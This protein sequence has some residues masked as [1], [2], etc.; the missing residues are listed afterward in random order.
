M[1]SV[2]SDVSNIVD[3]QHGSF[4]LE[5]LIGHFGSSS[6]EYLSRHQIRSL[7]ASRVEL[8]KQA[9]LALAQLAPLHE[10]R[11]FHDAFGTRAGISLFLTRMFLLREFVSASVGLMASGRD[12]PF[13]ITSAKQEDLPKSAWSFLARSC[14]IYQALGRF[15]GE[16]PAI[17][18]G[19]ETKLPEPLPYVVWLKE[20]RLDSRVAA[21]PA[22]VLRGKDGAVIPDVQFAP[23]GFDVLLEGSAQ[24]LQRNLIENLWGREVAETAFTLTNIS[25]HQRDADPISP[26]ERD[27]QSSALTAPAS[28]PKYNLTDLMISRY[29]G[30]TFSRKSVIALTDRALSE[31]FIGVNEAGEIRM[32]CPGVEFADSLPEIGSE[33]IVAG[34]IPPP[35]SAQYYVELRKSIR[36]TAPLEALGNDLPQALHDIETMSR[37]VAHEIILPMLDARLATSGKL[38][39][40]PKCYFDNL[41]T[42]PRIPF[43]LQPDGRVTTHAPLAIQ[44]AWARTVMMDRIMMQ[45]IGGDPIIRCPRAHALAPGMERINYALEGDCQNYV[46]ADL[47]GRHKSGASLG[48]LPNCQFAHTLH[49]LGFATSGAGQEAVSR[50]FGLAK[51]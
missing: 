1:T 9:D 51:L 3:R 39:S 42:L 49:E 28:V 30:Q 37:W 31:S 45:L 12:W 13:P 34:D 25:G 36:M 17:Y 4:H 16:I 27:S 18:P 40:D 7:Q 50:H 20:N 21:V 44:G 10:A 35:P 32:T 6:R 46:S 2:P 19:T 43:Q 48:S 23:I 8:K 38:L 41:P 22:Q 14:K 29:V 47:C 33:A 15:R 5:L 11:H 24:A 26:P